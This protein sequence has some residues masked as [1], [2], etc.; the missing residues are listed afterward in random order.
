MKLPVTRSKKKAY[1]PPKLLKY[2]SLT[3]ITAG[4]HLRGMKDSGSATTKT[5]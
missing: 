2:G 4:V 5:G 3:E 1:E